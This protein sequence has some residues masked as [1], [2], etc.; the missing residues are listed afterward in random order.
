MILLVAT[1]TGK[2]AIGP[3]SPASAAKTWTVCS[4]GCDFT[5]IQPAITAADAGDTIDIYGSSTAYA[6]GLVITENLTV[7]GVGLER[8]QSMAA[9][10]LLR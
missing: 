1:S 9:A 8:P 4:S 6:G 7:Q 2:L 3:P 5:A 10:P